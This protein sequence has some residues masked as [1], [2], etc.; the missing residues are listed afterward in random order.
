MIVRVIRA[1]GGVIQWFVGARRDAPTSEE[2]LKSLSKGTTTVDFG[3][4]RLGRCAQPALWAS[5]FVTLMPREPIQ[6]VH[7][8]GAAG[9]PL[10]AG[11]LDDPEMA[12]L[13]GR[14][15]RLSLPRS[16]PSMSLSLRPDVR[17][18]GVIQL[19]WMSSPGSC[20]QS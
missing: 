20:G 10:D 8:V 1:D 11:R 5:L 4:M 9:L 16:S 19:T 18:L 14:R 3:G 6:T 12:K 2:G 17:A 13:A 15:S 7:F